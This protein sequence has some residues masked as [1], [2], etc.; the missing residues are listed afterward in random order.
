MSSGADAALPPVR[1][2]V[3]IL[4]ISTSAAEG[5][6]TDLTT[7]VLVEAFAKANAVV[8]SSQWDVVG[9]ALVADR[10]QEIT[11]AIRKWTDD[12][13][14]E[15]RPNMNLVVTSG[16]TGFAVDDVT[17]EMHR[18]LTADSSLLEPSGGLWASPQAGARSS[19]SPSSHPHSHLQ[20]QTHLQSSI[21]T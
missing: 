20:A 13:N 6:T 4:T 16:G 3:G 9:T 12:S 18:I 5:T 19:V 14:Q 10:E 21:G 11:S 2:R 17:P 15:D 1:L 8:A 7:P